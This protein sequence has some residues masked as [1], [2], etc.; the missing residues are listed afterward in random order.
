MT[1]GDYNRSVKEYADRLYGFVLKHCRRS[2]WAEDIVQ[3]SFEAMWKHRS[4]I[5]VESAKAWLF[6]VAYNKWIDK[7]RKRKRDQALTEENIGSRSREE[8]RFI[9][10]DAA[11]KLLS[12]LT[13]TQRSLV[14]LREYEGYS[15]REIA[16][17]TEL[18]LSQVKV[19]LY[20]ARKRLS[21]TVESMKEK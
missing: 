16:D 5:R 10:R 17:I 1:T 13:E 2:D 18:S 9:A 21:A 19:Y 20:R 11:D 12:V 3:D 15:Y 8:H 4:E 7:K 14:M 6:K